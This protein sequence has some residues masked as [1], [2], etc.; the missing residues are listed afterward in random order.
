MRR[1]D[2]NLPS[3]IQVAEALGDLR[4][5]VVFLGGAVAGL[6]VTDPVAEGV[7]ATRDIDA[8]I[9]AGRA[10]FHRVEA[11]VSARG[12]TRDMDSAVICRWVHRES[13]ILF[14]LMPVD[15][16]V[17]GFSNRWYQFA[18]DTAQ[19]LELA[20]GLSIRLVSAVAFVATKLEAFAGRGAD[21]VLSSHDIEDVLNIVDGRPELADELAI[22]PADVRQAVRDAFGRLLARADFRNALPGLVAEPERAG[23][24]EDRLRTLAA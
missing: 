21:D 9:E 11:Q 17:L 23:I 20:D 19:P 12:F 2:P 15:P 5:R 13:G 18:V 16:G 7:R 6:L 14:D 3:L 22:A 8:V 1:D 10:N 4:D 24:V